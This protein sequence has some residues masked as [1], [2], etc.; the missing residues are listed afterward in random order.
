MKKKKLKKNVKILLILSIIVLIIML[1]LVGYKVCTKYIFVEKET[2]KEPGVKPVE[3]EEIDL[4]EYDYY[5]PSNT[6]EYEKEL[7]EELKVILIDETIDNDAY[8]NTIAKLF[9]SNLF[10]LNTKNSSSDITSSQYV[11]DDYKETFKI[12]VKD[13]IYANIELNL[14]DKRTQV[15]PVVTNIEITSVERKSFSLNKTVIDKEAYYIKANISYEKDLSYPKEY[16]IVLVKNN[17]LLQV[18]KAS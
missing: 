9:I 11:Y 7:F 8:A 4:E 10:T 17:N 6:T 18:V 2:E 15:L 13:T 12:M 5:I 14:D 1:I 16:S 3:K